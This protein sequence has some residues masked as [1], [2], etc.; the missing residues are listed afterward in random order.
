MPQSKLGVWEQY[1]YRAV[2]KQGQTVDFLLTAQRDREAAKRFLCKAI[3]SH[4]VP[5]KITI[6]KSG[7]N[8]AAIES[9]HAEQATAI[10]PCE[11]VFDPQEWQAAWI[12]AHR[13]PPPV[14]PPRLGEMVRL[15]ASFGGFLGR[16]SDG[17]PGL[18]AI[19]EGM[20]QIQAFAMGIA[21]AKEAFILTG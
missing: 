9:Y 12:V 10:E 13:R 11:V 14:T 1:L 21:A 4:G 18:K 16:K 2:D 17:H 6:D 20:Q 15:I 5:E 7:A 8:T 3:R 19:W